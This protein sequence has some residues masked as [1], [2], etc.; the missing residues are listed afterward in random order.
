MARNVIVFALFMLLI[1]AYIYTMYNATNMADNIT[2]SVSLERDPNSCYNVKYVTNDSAVGT[3]YTWILFATI[4]FVG[5]YLF[6][7]KKVL[8]G[9][10]GGFLLS[11]TIPLLTLGL[12]TL[13]FSGIYLWQKYPG[14]LLGFIFLARLVFVTIANI[15][16]RFGYGKGFMGPASTMGGYFVN[17]FAFLYQAPIEYFQELFNPKGQLYKETYYYNY[18]SPEGIV[19]PQNLI[20]FSEGKGFTIPSGMPWDF[21]GVKFIKVFIMVLYLMIFKS[22]PIDKKLDL[23]SLIPTVKEYKD[24]VMSNTGTNVS[25]FSPI[26]NFIYLIKGL[27]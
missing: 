3:Q 6:F 25:T 7:S 19:K 16:Y 10:G 14:P 2:N 11:V 12:S 21:P 23:G 4:V 27:F 17:L 26:A 9:S 22:S 20:N 15:I 1:T 24:K 8:A 5:L 13:M 18:F